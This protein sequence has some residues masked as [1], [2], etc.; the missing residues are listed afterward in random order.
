MGSGGIGCVSFSF[1]IATGKA[2]TS[3]CFRGVPAVG[4]GS[5]ST[6]RSGL[7]ISFIYSNDGAIIYN[8]DSDATRIISNAG[9]GAAGRRGMGSFNSCANSA[10]RD[11]LFA[12]PT[13]SGPRGIAVH[14]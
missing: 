2:G 10:T 12:I 4:I 1:G 9:L 3:F 7:H 11:P 14:I 13:S 5:T 8:G 6:S